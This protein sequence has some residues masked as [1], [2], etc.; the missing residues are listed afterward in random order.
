MALRASNAEWRRLQG[1]KA[2]ALSC[3]RLGEAGHIAAERWYPQRMQHLTRPVV[4]VE[5]TLIESRVWGL[6]I[7]GLLPLQAAG[8][9]VTCLSRWPAGVQARIDRG[10]LHG[11]CSSDRSPGDG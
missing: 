7:P 1:V 3:G 10:P 2:L 4:T 6:V 5:P 11:A 9:G 8:V